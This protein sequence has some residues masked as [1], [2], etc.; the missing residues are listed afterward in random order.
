MKNCL[1]HLISISISLESIPC[2]LMDKSMENRIVQSLLSIKGVEKTSMYAPFVITCSLV[3]SNDQ[4]RLDD[5]KR[6][7]NKANSILTENNVSIS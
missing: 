6:I 5:L 4:Q 7:L 3:G 2:H 1:S